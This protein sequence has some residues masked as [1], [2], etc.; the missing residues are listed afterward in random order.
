MDKKDY[1]E[2]YFNKTVFRLHDNSYGIYREKKIFETQ[3]TVGE[4]TTMP[5]E[6]FKYFRYC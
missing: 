5:Q 2:R 4:T 3:E 1:R 6:E